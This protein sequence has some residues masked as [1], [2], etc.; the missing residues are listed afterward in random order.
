MIKVINSKCQIDKEIRLWNTTSKNISKTYGLVTI[1]KYL[2]ETEIIYDILIKDGWIEQARISMANLD[3]NKNLYKYYSYL[4][5]TKILG[6]E[7][8][9]VESNILSYLNANGIIN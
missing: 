1:A 6:C 2:D 8:D 9:R 5:I 3:I 7:D 4:K